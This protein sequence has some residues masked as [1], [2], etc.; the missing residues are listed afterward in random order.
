[1]AQF[2][3]PTI[4]AISQ[5]P[6]RKTISDKDLNYSYLTTYQRINLMRVALDIE[7]TRYVPQSRDLAAH[8]DPTRWYEYLDFQDIPKQEEVQIKILNGTPADSL[9]AMV[10]GVSVGAAPAAQEWF[11]YDLDRADLMKV[12]DVQEWLHTEKMGS[13]RTIQNSNFY[14]NFSIF[15]RDAIVNIGGCM[16]VERDKKDVFKTTIFRPGQYR[17]ALDANGLPTAFQRTF[18]LTC[19]QIIET[20]GKRVDVGGGKTEWDISNFSQN[21]VTKAQSGLWDTWIDVIHHVGPNA[22]FDPSMLASKYNQW[23]SVYYELGVPP[24]VDIQQPEKFLR[25]EGYD[26][27]PIIFFPW[28]TDGK[29][30]YAINNPGIKALADTKEL[31]FLEQQYMLALDMATNKPL[32]HSE[33]IQ[34]VDTLPGGETILPQGTQAKDAI[35]PLYEVDLDLAHLEQRIEKKEQAV[36]QHFMADFFRRLVDNEQKQPIT[37][38]EVVEIKKEIMILLGP[39]F[40]GLTKYCLTPFIQIV[41]HLR[42]KAGL[43]APA[44]MVM[45]R[46]NLKPKFTSVIAKALQMGDFSLL[47]SGVEFVTAMAK[48][49]PNSVHVMDEY[50]IIKKGWDILGIDP[51]TL[52]KPEDYQATLQAV[53]KQQQ[54]EQAAKSAPAMASA[55]QTASETPAPGG[56]GGSMLDQL[57]AMRQGGT[58]VNA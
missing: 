2:S 50:K 7:W 16:F 56:Q 35:V 30:A 43:V 12:F 26:Y 37:A 38:T 44:P 15:L 36:K 13:Q 46:T 23:K 22:D 33:D 53:A 3:D 58:G 45:D 14:T 17:I 19:R 9:D 57:A 20:Y 39:A 8:F 4:Q 29:G 52:K 51:D 47:Q 48:D 54:A 10:S 24:Q 25:E 41:F 34:D 27:F 6:K 31:F 1:L 55:A 42:K 5:Q 40:H 21:V 28:E 32:A 18:R 11:D 49:I